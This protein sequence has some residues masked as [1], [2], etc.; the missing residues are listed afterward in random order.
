MERK[1]LFHRLLLYCFDSKRNGCRS[2]PQIHL[3][4]LFLLHQLKHV[5]IGFDYSKV[6]ILI[7]KNV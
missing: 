6:A 7:W 3:R 5:S 4:N 1:K 2:S